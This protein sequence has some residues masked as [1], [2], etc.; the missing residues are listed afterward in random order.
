MRDRTG[1]EPLRTF[2]WFSV[3]FS[4]T[5][6]AP[7]AWDGQAPTHP[8]E[9]ET[10]TT[11]R[12]RKSSNQTKKDT[13][14][15]FDVQNRK[16]CIDDMCLRTHPLYIQLYRKGT[17]S[18]GYLR[19]KF[20]NVRKQKKN[21]LAWLLKSSVFP[22]AFFWY[23]MQNNETGAQ[24]EL[25]HQSHMI[26][27]RSRPFGF[28][29]IVSVIEARNSSLCRLRYV[30]T[31]LSPQAN[32]F[33]HFKTTWDERTDPNSPVWKGAKSKSMAFPCSALRRFRVRSLFS[34][35]YWNGPGFSSVV[36]LLTGL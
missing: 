16:Q 5:E 18:L 1:P 27:S 6:W 32:R 7:A 11:Q 10:F 2:A 19:T 35:K 36:A 33:K 24:S 13:F 17:R 14:K 3:R 28:A 26:H 8:G 21:M 30:C 29:H 25:S 20:N 15:G 4:F 34:L 22:L 31:P 23:W 9:R 12:A